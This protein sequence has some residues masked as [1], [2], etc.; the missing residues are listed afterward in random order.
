VTSGYGFSFFLPQIVRRLS[1]GSDLAV[2]LW[3]AVPFLVAAIGMITIA[4]NSDRTG[5]RRWHVACCAA[6]AATG[7]ACS[8]LG[9][10]PLLTLGALALGAIG[11]YS[12]T[13]PFWS[14]PTAFLRGDGAAAGI[15]LINSVGNLGGFVGPYLMGWM[16]NMSG[17]FRIGI[18]LLAASAVC[19]GLLVL[20]MRNPAARD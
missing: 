8:S 17:D 6:L 4:A 14:L 13:P 11:L 20:T 10:S 3:T 9:G 18:R 12:A 1:G 2:G 15:A 5:E 7:L 16:Q 19:S